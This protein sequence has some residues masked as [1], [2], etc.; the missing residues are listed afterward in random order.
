MTRW[1]LKEKLSIST[2]I[3]TFFQRAFYFTANVDAFSGN[4]GSP[5]INKST[6]KVEGILI[7]GGR[8][9][10][11]N[12]TDACTEV[13]KKS[14]EADVTEEVAFKITKVRDLTMIIKN[15]NAQSRVFKGTNPSK[16]SKKIPGDE[17]N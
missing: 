11:H 6:G 5:I 10:Q 7:E 8:D 14:D 15:S 2:R 16:N 13:V 12:Y 17:D 4:S 1:N 9:Y 3:S